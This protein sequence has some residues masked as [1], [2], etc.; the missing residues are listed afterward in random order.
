M[1]CAPQSSPKARL[2]NAVG[3]NQQIRWNVIVCLRGHT[4]ILYVLL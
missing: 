2:I 1:Q 4:M 3:S